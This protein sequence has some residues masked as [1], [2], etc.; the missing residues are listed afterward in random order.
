MNKLKFLCSKT[1]VLKGLIAATANGD[2]QC[3]W[4]DLRLIFVS[5]LKIHATYIQSMGWESE[6]PRYLATNYHCMLHDLR[7]V[8]LKV[9]KNAQSFSLLCLKNLLD[10]EEKTTLLSLVDC[11]KERLESSA[12]DACASSVLLGEE[13][14]AEELAQ[15]SPGKRKAEV[16][17]ER[18][19]QDDRQDA[20]YE[21]ALAGCAVTPKVNKKTRELKPLQD[22]EKSDGSD[23]SSIIK[24]HSV[25]DAK[26]SGRMYI[27]GVWGDSPKRRLVCEITMKQ[28][29]DYQEHI[30]SIA[31]RLGTASMTKE[32]AIALRDKLLG[33]V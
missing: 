19:M 3:N 2:G 7:E 20:I 4:S 29:A 5:V 22:I 24:N 6:L 26:K 11:I 1:D 27:L 15:C 8:V 25:V 13:A 28:S 17:I 14:F 23:R 9:M 33:R 12:G 18:T 21:E 10:T 16:P 32:E 30:K 31:A